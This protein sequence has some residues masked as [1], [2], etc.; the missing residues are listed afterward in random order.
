MGRKFLGQR[1]KWTKSAPPQ[2]PLSKGGSERNK[3]LLDVL[4]GFKMG[5]MWT[6]RGVLAHPFLT[7]NKRGTNS[8]S[9]IF[10]GLF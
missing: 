3:L 5:A 9:L 2:S 8:L 4:E 6:N 7:M 10:S 1:R